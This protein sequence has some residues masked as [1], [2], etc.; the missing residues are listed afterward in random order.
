MFHHSFHHILP[1]RMR[2]GALE[3]KYGCNISVSRVLE[4][5]IAL[6]TAFLSSTYSSPVLI[7]VN[8]VG[9]ISLKARWF[10]LVRGQ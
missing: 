9:S 2:L 5:A 7:E 10:C 4:E 8:N 6:I 3:G 1:K